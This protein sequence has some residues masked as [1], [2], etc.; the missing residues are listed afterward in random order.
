MKKIFTTILISMLILNT[1][2]AK[3]TKTIN[4]IYIGNKI[5]WSKYKDLENID[6]IISNKNNIFT[7]GNGIFLG[8]KI[9]KNLSFELGYDWLGKLNQKKKF[10]IHY[11]N[12]QGIYLL[13]KI[14][15][16]INKKLDIYTRIG[17]ILTKSIFNKINKINKNNLVF[18]NTM[19]SP[20]ISFGL[21]YKIN[22]YLSS[23]LDYQFI[24]KIGDKNLIKE[25]TNNNFLNISLIYLKEKNKNKFNKYINL[26]INFYQN[27]YLFKIFNKYKLDE[28][29]N[30]IYFYNKNIYKIKIINYLTTNKN[31]FN[32]LKTLYDKINIIEKYLVYKG[33]NPLKIEKKI[34]DLS[35]N[36]NYYINYLKLVNSINI[37]IKIN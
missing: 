19:L 23:R 31:K 37:K 32:N 16:P 17:N 4:K 25:E 6:K 35:N 22:K 7:K 11:F 21:E 10:L 3:K 29:I 1:T 9:N 12:S 30:K 18:K 27:N 34:Y 8:Y 5:G 20:I 14:S 13:T 24:Y 36:K 33:I 28:L 26:K 2:L 15:Y